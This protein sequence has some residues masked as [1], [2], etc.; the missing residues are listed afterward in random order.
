MRAQPV[1]VLLG[2]LGRR[3]GELASVG[4]ERGEPRSELVD[5]SGDDRLR[6]RSVT[7]LAGERFAVVDY[8]VVAVVDGGDGDGDRFAFRPR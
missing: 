6:Q 3:D 8:S 4:A 5:V 7:G 1:E 2:D